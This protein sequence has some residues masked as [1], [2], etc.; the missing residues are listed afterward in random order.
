MLVFV[1]ESGDPGLNIQK[2]S[3]RYFTIALVA[4]DDDKEAE[5][6]DAKIEL[7]RHELGWKPNS[8]FHFAT[9]SNRVRDGFL[10]A[11]APY[12]FFYYGIIINKDPKKLYGAGFR[13]KSSFYKYACSL[14]FNNAKEK[15]ENSTVVIDESGSS[16]FKYQL[17]YYLR[18]H[19]N[20]AGLAIKKVK[21]ER[22][23]SNNLLQLADYV[24]GVINRNA[25]GKDTEALKDIIAH[26]E[27]YIQIWPK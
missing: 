17:A 12:N 26:R 11:V 6:C 13:D 16:D 14:V 21:S 20:G 18:R 22:S 24:A 10:R 23:H 19:M 1:D 8:E 15:L 7:L 5:K 4:F 9:N 27:I 25:L 2:G 3:S